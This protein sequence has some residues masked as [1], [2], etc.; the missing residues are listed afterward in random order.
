MGNEKTKSEGEMGVAAES[1]L[2]HAAAKGRYFGLGGT[3][4]RWGGQVLFFDKRDNPTNQPDWNTIVD[5]NNTYRSVVLKNLL[6]AGNK[7]LVAFEDNNLLESS[8]EKTGIWLKY[9]K[10]NLFKGLHKADLKSINL[11][12]NQR[13]TDFILDGT[14]IKSVICSDTEGNKKKITA[15]IFYLTAGAIES[16]RL[17]LA[18]NE[19]HHLITSTDLGKHYG[20]HISVELIKIKGHK[21]VIGQTNFLPNLIHGSLITKRWIVKDSDNRMGYAH[22]VFNSDVKIFT[23]IKRLLFGK[24]QIDFNVKDIAEGFEFLVRFGYSVL[25]R[26][27]LYA[28]RNNWSIRLDLEQVYPNENSI[29]LSDRTDKYGQKAAVLNWSVSE[30][31]KKSLEE[32]KNNLVNLLEKEKVNH[33]VIFDPSVES[34]KIE[35]VYHPVGFLRMGHDENSVLDIDCRVRG[36]DNLYHFSTAMFPSAKSINPTAAGFCFIEQHIFNTALQ[37]KCDEK[38]AFPT[39]QPYS[40]SHTS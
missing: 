9:T 2:S 3:S 30:A 39:Q 22:P 17:L 8:N 12:K 25:V 18:M 1:K 34:T 32:I 6:G 4:A 15:D 35:D 13:V 31:D 23:S 21:P 16:C 33:E 5:V 37:L 7:N 29:S 19:K 36:I 14:Q 10:R 24:Q 26:K 38:N 27:K 40:L 11:I 28:H 20:D